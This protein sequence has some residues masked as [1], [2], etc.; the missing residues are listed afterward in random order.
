MAVPDA[1]DADRMMRG[2]VD[3]TAVP[4]LKCAVL[5]L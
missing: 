2:S 1:T 5:C 3:D 4:T